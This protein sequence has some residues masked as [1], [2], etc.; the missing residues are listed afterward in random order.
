MAQVT[1]GVLTQGT[2]VWILHGDT[3]TPT[4]TKVNCVKSI[5][6]GDD[7]P[8]EIDSTCLDETDTKTSEWGLNT[9]GE[10]SLVIDTDP[11]NASH[12]ALLQAAANKETVEVYVGWADGTAAPTLSGTDVT[13]PT[14][15]TWSSFTAKLRENS[16]VFDADSLVNHTIAMKRQTRVVT[17]YKTT[18]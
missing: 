11:D 1:K 16:P 9:P 2:G 7:S 6:L 8:T 3:A 10:G 4:L 18:V 15:R 14:T 17:A 12:I 5:S 13:L